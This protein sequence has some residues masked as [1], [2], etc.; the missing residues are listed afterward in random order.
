MLE[1][2][3]A[4]E[5]FKFVFALTAWRGGKSTRGINNGERKIMSL[6]GN[7]VCALKD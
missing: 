6:N 2:Q 7:N 1:R 5:L 4:L 3:K